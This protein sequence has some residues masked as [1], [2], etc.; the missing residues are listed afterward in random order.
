MKSKREELQKQLTKVLEDDEN[1]KKIIEK[2][3]QLLEPGV[4]SEVD[5]IHENSTR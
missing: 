5:E 3:K 2:F 4:L 1:I